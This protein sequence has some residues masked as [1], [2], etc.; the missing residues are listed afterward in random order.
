MYSNMHRQNAHNMSYTIINDQHK[1]LAWDPTKQISYGRH[2]SK[3]AGGI[4]SFTIALSNFILTLNLMVS[5]PWLIVSNPW[6]ETRSSLSA[7]NVTT[8]LI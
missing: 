8:Q 5:N 6:Y 3:M 4:L 2:A 1:F 7:R